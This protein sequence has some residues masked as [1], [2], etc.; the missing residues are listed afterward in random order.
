ACDRLRCTDCNF[1][2]LCFEGRAW[3]A[4]ID[5]MFLRNNAPDPAKLSARLTRSSDGCAYACQ[6]SWTNV[7]EL[8]LLSPT[9]RP[10]WACGGH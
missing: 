6:C 8:T 10:R 7:K 4:N 2:V 1:E 9:E 5:Y 3:D